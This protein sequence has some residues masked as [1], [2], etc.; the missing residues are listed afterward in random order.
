MKDGGKEKMKGIKDEFTAEEIADL[1][2]LLRSR[3]V[4]GHDLQVSWLAKGGR[5]MTARNIR[6]YLG[7]GLTRDPLA[8][9]YISKLQQQ[10]NSG[11][12]PSNPNKR[13][14][15]DVQAFWKRCDLI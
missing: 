4:T 2:K 11:R 9:R 8:Q 6:D 13:L 10:L 5:P 12:I 1:V 14:P 15:Q 3:Q 7:K